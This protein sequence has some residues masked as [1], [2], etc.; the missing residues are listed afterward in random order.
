M[1]NAWR[2]DIEKADFGYVGR[3]TIS[4]QKDHEDQGC[5][6]CTTPLREAGSTVVQLQDSTPH[7]PCNPQAYS[8]RLL[9]NDVRQAQM[10]LINP[11]ALTP[12]L[13]MERF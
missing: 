9:W 11:Y 10:K 5:R 1:R 3:Y 4:S 7:M 12:T 6:D 2:L 8:M 13:S